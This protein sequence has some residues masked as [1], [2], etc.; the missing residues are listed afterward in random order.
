[1]RARRRG[2]EL[3]IRPLS[4]AERARAC[5]LAATY[6]GI[7]GGARGE[8]RADVEE[9]LAAVQISGR[10][11]RLADGL[12]KLL[13]DRCRFEMAFEGDPAA[14]RGQVYLAAAA[15]RRAGAFDRAA[16]LVAAGEALGL[17]PEA[18]DAA[19]H[20]DLRGEQRLVELTPIDPAALVAAYEASQIQAA[21]L[22]A[23]RVVAEVT[24][25]SPDA[26]RALFRE[27][28]FRRLLHQISPREG[29]G[30]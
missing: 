4:A 29:G 28:K 26:Y 19:L 2:D 30:Y 1:M 5:E 15:A 14:L 21:L 24:C 8:R 16:V 22:R 12:R 17:P 23:V 10:E 20:A 18:V 7:L 27:L 25:R 3:V 11:K 9:A 6:T 13:E